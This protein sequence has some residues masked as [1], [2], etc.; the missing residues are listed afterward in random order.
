MIWRR[1]RALGPHGELVGV[2][3]RCGFGFDQLAFS[4]D[5]W[6]RGGSYVLLHRFL[7]DLLR[8]GDSDPEMRQRVAVEPGTNRPCEKPCDA[9][10]DAN[11]HCNA[12]G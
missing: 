10:R 9:C 3:L 11:E 4:G 2:L 8:Y 1:L 5:V 6:G 12:R 7:R